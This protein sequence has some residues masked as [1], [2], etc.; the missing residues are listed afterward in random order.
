[1][2]PSRL[3]LRWVEAKKKESGDP[4]L[5][6]HTP[7]TRPRLERSRHIRKW[8]GNSADRGTL[9]GQEF[10]C[11]TASSGTNRQHPVS[12][13]TL[14]HPHVPDCPPIV[15]K[16]PSICLYSSVCQREFFIQLLTS[17]TSCSLSAD[18]SY[19]AFVQIRTEVAYLRRKF[20]STC[21]CCH[22]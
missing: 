16:A 15:Y 14:P 21:H 19:Y 10:D 4:K 18:P 3:S 17:A 5:T 20:L 22:G 1:M 8:L 12:E 11:L 9:N 2:S 6:N 13:C 7:Y